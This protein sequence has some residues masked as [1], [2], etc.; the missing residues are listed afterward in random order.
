MFLFYSTLRFK[1]S[2]KDNCIVE[3]WCK[4]LEKAQSA[5]KYVNM[6][7]FEKDRDEIGEDCY[8]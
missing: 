8:L 5:C 7:V 4:L 1:D 6:E 2:T 3:V